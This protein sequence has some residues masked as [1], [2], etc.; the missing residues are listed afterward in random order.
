MANICDN[1]LRVISENKK[2]FKAV[3]KYF[4]DWQGADVNQID[5][6]EMEVYFDSKWDFPEEEM[7]E[8]Y[9]SIQDKK[10][11]YMTCLSVEYGNMYHALW[12]CDEDGWTEA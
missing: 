2:V 9:N 6:N 8:L 7:K 10:D 5:D 4:K 12:E 11:I 1:T 3:K